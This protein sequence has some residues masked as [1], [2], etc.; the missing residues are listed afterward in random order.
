LRAASLRFA[1]F[2]ASGTLSVLAKRLAMAW[3][4]LV[5]G[6]AGD[7]EGDDEQYGGKSTGNAGRAMVCEAVNNARRFELDIA[8]TPSRKAQSQTAARTGIGRRHHVEYAV[9]N[10]GTLGF[11][12]PNGR[13]MN[14]A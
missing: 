4:A 11:W 6:S 1:S 14:A 5:V 7:G 9:R 13:P 8:A 12:R 3:P 10:D 2:A